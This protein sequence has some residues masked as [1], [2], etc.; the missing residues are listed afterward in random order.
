MAEA[1]AKMINS[2]YETD[3]TDVERFDE[4]LGEGVGAGVGEGVGAGV[5]GGVTVQQQ[6]D[7]L[8]QLVMGL[9]R[10]SLHIQKTKKNVIEKIMSKIGEE[11]QFG[12]FKLE[13]FFN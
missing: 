5:G 2:T 7:T 6:F 3:L 4:E 12:T 9:L 8:L 11:Y 10:K 1:I 13:M